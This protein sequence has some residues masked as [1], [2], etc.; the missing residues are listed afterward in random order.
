MTANCATGPSGIGFAGGAT[1]CDSVASQKLLVSV[2]MIWSEWNLCGRNV[3]TLSRWDWMWFAY[4]GSC[5]QAKLH[6]SHSV[7]AVRCVTCLF[8]VFQIH[9]MWKPSHTFPF[10]IRPC[11]TDLSLIYFSLV[12][13]VRPICHWAVSQRRVP[14]PPVHR[15]ARNVPHHEHRIRIFFDQ[16]TRM[17]LP[18]ACQVITL[19]S[20]DR[21]RSVSG[22]TPQRA[23]DFESRKMASFL[24][25]SI[26]LDDFPNQNPGE[27][28]TE[29][30]WICSTVPGRSPW[31]EPVW[32]GCWRQTHCRDIPKIV[33]FAWFCMAMAVST[34]SPASSSEVRCEGCKSVVAS[35]AL[36]QCDWKLSIGCSHCWVPGGNSE[37]ANV[38]HTHRI[39]AV[40]SLYVLKVEMVYPVMPLANFNKTAWFS[41]H[42]TCLLFLWM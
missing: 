31:R 7:A 30:A 4:S 10:T 42:L 17:M 33:V 6:Q 1:Q 16:I 12:N 19:Y 18:Q 9:R 3:R 39:S 32:G 28:N 36:L 2:G 34:G 24:N 27:A 29:T 21:P 11:P 15:C 5:L 8:M 37:G 26:E 14:Q 41:A 38:W 40:F 13:D 35:V 22:G 20:V 25:D 23:N